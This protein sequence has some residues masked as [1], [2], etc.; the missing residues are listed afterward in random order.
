L[1]LKKGNFGA[2]ILPK[3]VR[4]KSK[5]EGFARVNQLTPASLITPVAGLIFETKNREIFPERFFWRDFS[6][7]ALLHVQV[8]SH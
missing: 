1:T 5:F 6:G 3:L 4:G 7:A 8:C 2:G